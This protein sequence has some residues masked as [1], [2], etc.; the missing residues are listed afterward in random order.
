MTRAANLAGVATAG[1]ALLCVTGS[2]WA[3]GPV[4]VPLEGFSVALPDTSSPSPLVILEFQL[5]Q[6]LSGVEIDD[7][8]LWL[9]AT[10]EP[11]QNADVR[12]MLLL[13]SQPANAGR[14]GDHRPK[15]VAAPRGD[16]AVW[17]T[18]VSRHEWIDEGENTSAS[19]WVGDLVQNRV[20]RREFGLD[21]VVGRDEGVPGRIAIWLPDRSP[22]EEQW[23]Y[24]VVHYSRRDD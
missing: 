2:S 23:P 4:S 11:H 18:G 12:Q 10:V 15:D 6:E 8:H 19:I 3:I 7:A 5:P 1:F 22:R 21:L 9:C 13:V 14:S 17:D 16:G 24:L 20:A